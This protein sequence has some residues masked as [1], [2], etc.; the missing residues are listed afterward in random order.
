MQ[1][2]VRADWWE[3][4]ASGWHVGGGLAAQFL[5]RQPIGKPCQEKKSEKPS[6]LGRPQSVSCFSDCFGSSCV[7]PCVM[8]PS[9]TLTGLACAGS[10]PACSHHPWAGPGL[11]HLRKAVSAMAH[12]QPNSLRHAALSGG[13]FS[14]LRMR[15]MKVLPLLYFLPYAYNN[16]GAA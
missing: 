1:D 13:C 10:P 4:G 11:R 3:A 14:Q 7:K 5:N 9:Q 16:S 12:F 6:L 2:P 15:K 8:S